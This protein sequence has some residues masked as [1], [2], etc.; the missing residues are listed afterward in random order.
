MKYVRWILILAYVYFIL[1]KTVIGRPVL[2]EPIFKGLFWEVQNGMW[3]DIR[4][5]ILL[6]IPLGFLIGGW[7]VILACLMLSVGIEVYQYF[8]RVGY[9]EI[10][11]VINNAFGSCCG[12]LFKYMACVV[13]KKLLYGGK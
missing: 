12:V 3:S 13:Y 9:C 7:K 4:L 5:N 2:P 6:F 10:D 1:T 8:G 11:D